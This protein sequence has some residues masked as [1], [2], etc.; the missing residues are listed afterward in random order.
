[1]HEPALHDLLLALDILHFIPPR[2]LLSAP[3][4]T[5]ARQGLV[6]IHPRTSDPALYPEGSRRRP[7]EQRRLA[8]MNGESGDSIR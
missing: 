2:E 8:H 3:A 1:M 4:T 5:H 7:A 6:I